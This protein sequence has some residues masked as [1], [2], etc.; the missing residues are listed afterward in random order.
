MNPPE[1]ELL[2]H[3]ATTGFDGSPR[4]LAS[5]TTGSPR[6]SDQPPVY[7]SSQPNE[8]SGCPPDGRYSSPMAPA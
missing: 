7:R 8:S 5:T 3:L 4:N 1:E 6:C 2:D